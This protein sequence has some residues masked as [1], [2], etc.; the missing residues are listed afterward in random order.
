[1]T[2]RFPHAKYRITTFVSVYSPT[3]DKSDDVNGRVSDT[4]YST[5]R[6]ISHED[7]VILLGDFYARVGRNHN[8]LHGVIGHHGVGNMNSSDLQL[9]S[10][11]SE[12]GLAI[13]NTFFQ[14]R[15]VHKTSWM[16]PRS[17]Q[18]QLIDYITIRRRDWNEVHIIRAMR[19]AECSTDHLLIR[20]TLRL[21][22]RSPARR[23]KPRRKL[24]VHAAYNENIRGTA[25]C[26]CPIFVP[27]INDYY[28]KLHLNPYYG[29]AG[30]FLSPTNCF[31]VNCWLHG[32]TTSRLVRW[33]CHWHPFSYPRK[34]C[35]TRCSLA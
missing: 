35:C 8:I 12:F 1:M 26:H 2:L 16:H 28:I 34:R 3:L 27:N 25:Q 22:V 21:S 9:L 20:S 14:L 32:E 15:D 10:L 7:K 6:R 23:Q 4:L 30:S 18:W 29:V 19:G 24:N 33:Q 5:L 11:C 13:T 31:A 17:K